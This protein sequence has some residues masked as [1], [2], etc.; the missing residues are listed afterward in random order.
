MEVPR[1]GVRYEIQ[2]LAYTTPTAMQDLSHICDLHHSSWQ[3]QI[4]NP[5]A[6]DQTA[7]SWI[8]VSFITAE[9]QWEL[10][11]EYHFVLM[12]TIGEIANCFKPLSV[13]AI[14]ILKLF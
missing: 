11:K 10:P 8:L 6:R 4:P 7:S 9:P 14:A 2:L 1:L 3:C 5:L 12:S 13:I